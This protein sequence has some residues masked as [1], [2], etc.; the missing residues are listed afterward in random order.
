MSIPPASPFASAPSSRRPEL[1]LPLV[2]AVAY[3]APLG[4][5]IPVAMMALWWLGLAWVERDHHTWGLS[6]RRLLRANPAL[7][8]VVGLGFASAAW[9]AV[10]ATA[11]AR[12]ERLPLEVL[13]AT[14]LV[15][16]APHLPAARRGGPLLAVLWTAAATGLLAALDVALGGALSGWGRDSTALIDV[17]YSRGAVVHALLLPAAAI[18]AWRAGLRRGTAAAS[19]V[20]V[21]ALLLNY[22][23]TG[24]AAL[25]LGVVVVAAVLALPML[26]RLVAP[27]LAL[28]VLAMP[29][30]APRADGPL[31]CAALTAGAS[32]GHR[33]HI[34]TF[35]QDR[36]AERPLLGWGLEAGRSIPGGHAPVA[37]RACVDGHPTGALLA[38]G[39]SMPLHPHNAALQV[40]LNLGFI[41]ALAVA[42]AVGWMVHRGIAAADGRLGQ[43]TVAATAVVGFAIANVSFGLWQSWLIAAFTAAAMI[44]RIAAAPSS[45]PGE[46]SRP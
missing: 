5:W 39:E 36:I 24:R 2:P 45:A 29:L 11:L 22:S 13:A 8:A 41:G 44:A 16:A 31:Y 18:G 28:V 21:A 46:G 37:V 7:W 6:P 14:T 27:G 38:R 26:R 34:W 20:G 10:P 32:T 43:A 40:W 23:G 17:A 33:I 12:A 15:L 35:T 4:T 25:L 3:V 42:L 30:I 1:L 19:V 9:A